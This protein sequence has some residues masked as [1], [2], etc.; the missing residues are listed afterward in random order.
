[1]PCAQQEKGLSPGP[2][3]KPFLDTTGR[4]CSWHEASDWGT[5]FLKS[6]EGDALA[7][8]HFFFHVQTSLG[9][10]YSFTEEGE[11]GFWARTIV[12]PDAVGAPC[13]HQLLSKCH[14]QNATHTVGMSLSPEAS[15]SDPILRSGL[16]ECSV[17]E[18][19]PRS[20]GQ[21]AQGRRDPHLLLLGTAMS[22]DLVLLSD[23]PPMS[24]SP[25]TDWLQAPRPGKGSETGQWFLQR[26]LNLGSH[27]FRCSDQ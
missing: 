21:E 1:M 13:S 15:L 23:G 5:P 10:A 26:L 24:A 25:R 8:Y 9:P 22:S 20:R 6:K 3:G 7:F 18:P 11:W 17:R 27:T 14:W 19:L 12:A 4:M 16:P 2:V